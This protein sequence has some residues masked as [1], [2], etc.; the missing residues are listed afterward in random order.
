MPAAPM[1]PP[2]SYVEA[3]KP[4]TAATAADLEA[5]NAPPPPLSAAAAVPIS[6][7]PGKPLV[8]DDD[9]NNNNNDPD[10]TPTPTPTA[11]GLTPAAIGWL[12]FALGWLIALIWLIGLPVANVSPASCGTQAARLLASPN[13]L[14]QIV[15]YERLRS[16]VACRLSTN[17]ALVATGALC[18]IPWLLGSLIPCCCTTSRAV[19]RAHTR[20]PNGGCAAALAAAKSCRSRAARANT[21]MAVLGVAALAGLVAMVSA[22]M[23]EAKKMDTPEARQQLE[24][25]S[26]VAQAGQSMAAAVDGVLEQVGAALGIPKPEGVG[27]AASGEGL[28]GRLFKP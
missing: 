22:E 9:H 13:P 15:A 19:E 3:T 16:L 10:F 2:A 24:Q 8:V 18:L 27:S 1:P 17:I 21:T 28:L 20:K 23:R 14:A 26:G 4:P 25:L 5:G 6:V 12:L 11:C 7:V